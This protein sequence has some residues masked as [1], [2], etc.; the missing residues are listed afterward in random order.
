MLAKIINITPGSGF[1]NSTKSPEV[2]KYIKGSKSAFFSIHDSV[3]FS[4]AIQFLTRIEWQLKELN[5]AANEKLL[6]TFSISELEF[7]VMIDL[8][9]MN[10]LSFITYEIQKNKFDSDN[11]KNLIVLTSILSNILYD[12]NN[13]SIHLDALNRLFDRFEKLNIS[14]ELNGVDIETMS[15][16]V[17]DLTIQL[18]SEFEYIN[19]SLLVFIDKLTGHRVNPQ[20][21]TNAKRESGIIIEKMKS[22]NA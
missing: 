20:S 11:K 7:R 17:D 4:P 3:N 5:Q 16:L 6:I 12:E 2:M 1:K 15:Y 10:K 18:Q 13:V 9:V 19:K 21:Q 22:I 14:N 8:S